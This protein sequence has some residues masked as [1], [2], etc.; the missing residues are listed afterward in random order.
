MAINYFARRLLI[1]VAPATI[2]S[3]V[4]AVDPTAPVVPTDLFMAAPGT[5]TGQVARGDS[6]MALTTDGFVFE[7]GDSQRIQG[8]DRGGND[9]GQMYVMASAVGQ[10][11]FVECR[12]R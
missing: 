10:Y 12:V 8:G 5:N 2:R 4:Q 11:L 6:A 7:A 9:L 3:L 1:P